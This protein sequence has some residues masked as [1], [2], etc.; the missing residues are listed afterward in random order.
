MFP[1]S[2]FLL[3]ALPGCTDDVTSSSDSGPQTDSDPLPWGQESLNFVTK[4]L[5]ATFEGTWTLSG[6]DA[7]DT[8]LESMSWTDV[9]IGSNPRIDGDRALVDVQNDMDGGT[10]THSMTFNEGVLIE[11]DGS[12]GD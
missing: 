11:E 10:W 9:A 3:S 12:M 6:L 8:P 4:N 2:L 7:S 1:I 5:A